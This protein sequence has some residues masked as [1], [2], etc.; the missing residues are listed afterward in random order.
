MRRASLTPRTDGERRQHF[1]WFACSVPSVRLPVAEEGALHFLVRAS[2]TEGRARLHA[3]ATLILERRDKRQ[4]RKYTLRPV[5][6]MSFAP[7]SPCNASANTAAATKKRANTTRARHH[8]FSGFGTA[9]GPKSVPDCVRERRRGKTSG[10][11]ATGDDT[12]GTICF[13]EPAL[14]R[15]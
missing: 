9:C 5:H 14:P 15:V 10:E 11:D 7:W 1:G 3:P 12:E 13:V 8:S 4:E 2:W 6:E